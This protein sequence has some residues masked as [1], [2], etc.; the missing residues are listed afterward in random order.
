MSDG[1]QGVP[2]S[3][4]IRP[5]EESKRCRQVMI[6]RNSSL[7]TSQ[8]KMIVGF[9]AIVLGIIGAVFY[10]QGLWMVLPFA[11][12]EMMAVAAAFYC[13]VRHKQDYEMV[14]I[15]ENHIQVIRQVAHREQ[16]YE[17]QTHWTSVFL[18]F[19]RGWYPSRLWVAS[20]GQHVELGQWLTDAERQQLAT[21]LKYLIKY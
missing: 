13:C 12:F 14:K 2:S 18:E 20:K 7:S 1:S 3:V 6:T 15:D 16:V 10:S 9:I 21:R 4:T 5:G 8:I 17:F 11:G 19:T